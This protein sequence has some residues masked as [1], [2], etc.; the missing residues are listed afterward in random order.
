MRR[1][2]L[3]LLMA[4]VMVFVLAA[5][6]SNDKKA[7]PEGTP[8]D[9]TAS[10]ETSENKEEKK[11]EE[12]EPETENKE[13]NPL[14]FEYKG[15]KIW[16]MDEAEAV[17]SQLGDPI[18]V[19]EAD[20]CAFQ[21]KD[22]FHYFDGVQFQ[23]NDVEGTDRVTAITVADDTIKIPQGLSIGNPES[24]IEEALGAEHETAPGMYIYTHGTTRLQ[25]GVKEGKVSEIVYAYSLA[26]N[27]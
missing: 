11:E 3:V 17:E 25:I 10:A 2:I 24:K 21:G 18:S 8:A 5:C 1:R 19:F 13:D 12:K 7:E 20:S 15:V 4:L 26:K 22:I 6:S 27:G 14:Y 23:I 9:S 16:I